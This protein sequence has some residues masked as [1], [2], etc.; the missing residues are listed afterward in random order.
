MFCMKKII[1]VA[2][3]F[4]CF[5]G[6]AGFAY[7]GTISSTDKY[8]WGNYAG[9]LNFGATYGDVQVI[10]SK[11]SGYVWSDNF[12]WINLSP[13]QSGVVNNG[14]GIFSGYAWGENAGW[15]DFSGVSVGC[16]GQFTGA[17]I[18]LNANLGRV[19]FDCLPLQPL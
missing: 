17:A 5:F 6:L 13:T 4:I 14:Q 8:A 18:F 10:D 15:L 3:F 7:A 1:V 16:D 19:S 12:G 11:L 2:L 9:W